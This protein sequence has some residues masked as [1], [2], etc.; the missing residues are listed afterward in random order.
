MRN[1]VLE[2]ILFQEIRHWKA[3]MQLDCWNIRIAFLNPIHASHNGYVDY[4]KKAKT[5]LFFYDP[6][7]PVEDLI[8]WVSY[9]MKTIA[10]QE[11]DI[12]TKRCHLRFFTPEDFDDY[13]EIASDPEVTLPH[14]YAAYTDKNS[15]YQQFNELLKRTMFAIELLDEH[16][17]IGW[18]GL[19]QVKRAVYTLEFGFCIHSKYQHQGYGKE[20]VQALMQDCFERI[21]CEGLTV[22]HFPDN[23]ASQK[24]IQS[25][26]FNYEGLLRKSY[27][28]EVWGPMDLMSYSIFQD[29]Y[30]K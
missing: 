27:M 17:V 16:K 10:L 21:Y 8:Q 3:K 11:V 12:D 2:A 30:R 5:A 15:A 25:C 14:G 22:N 7:L 23:I 29:E 4:D 26:G 18:I 19:H 9:Q 28:H 1:P 20:C 6:K 24:L 13:Y